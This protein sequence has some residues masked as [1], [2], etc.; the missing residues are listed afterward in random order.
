MIRKEKNMKK[1]KLL[2]KI[3]ALLLTLTMAVPCFTFGAS[4]AQSVGADDLPQDY[5]TMLLLNDLNWDKT[6]IYALDENGE[7]VCGRYPGVELKEKIYDSDNREI[8]LA[9]LPDGIESVFF[10]DGGTERTENIGYLTNGLYRITDEQNSQQ[11][12]YALEEDYGEDNVIWIEAGL[13]P[14][15]YFYPKNIDGQPYYDEPGID[16][17]SYPKY[18]FP[19]NTYHGSFYLIR[20]PEDFK[21]LKLTVKNGYYGDFFY[22]SCSSE[23]GSHKFYIDYYS[24]FEDDLY[25]LYESCIPCLTDG[26]FTRFQYGD[27]NLDRRINIVD[28]TRI[29]Y[30]LAEIGTPMDQ[31]NKEVSDVTRDDRLNISDATAIQYYIADYYYGYA[32]TGENYIRAENEEMK[33]IKVYDT[34]PWDKMF[35][36]AW[37]ADGNLLCGNSPGYAAVPV[38][39]YSQND[40]ETLIYE[41]YLPKKA[42]KMVLSNSKGEKTAEINPQDIPDDV[43]S[44]F[45]VVKYGLF[46]TGEKDENGNA[47]HKIKTTDIMII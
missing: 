39:R 45:R 28:V 38:S 41:L 23:R 18:T 15:V 31:L 29:Q 47:A 2:K 33:Y 7:E 27:A 12:K 21:S 14:K 25:D 8:L 42:V 32:Q 9:V 16:I 34:N 40:K 36:S 5:T 13:G 24:V 1:P 17:T 3:I 35:V 6:Y 46:L 19:E 20:V 22:S 11:Y 37:D 44:R 43:V 10:S 26:Y 4:A 30:E